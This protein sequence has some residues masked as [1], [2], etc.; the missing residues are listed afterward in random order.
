MAYR[1]VAQWDS[2]DS[3]HQPSTYFYK[4]VFTP[5]AAQWDHAG[6]SLSCA[7]KDRLNTIRA[8]KINDNENEKVHD[9]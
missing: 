6:D 1:S 3:V 7:P 8:K 4:I 2:I 9:L 5:A